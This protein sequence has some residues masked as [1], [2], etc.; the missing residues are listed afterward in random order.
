MVIIA[1]TQSADLR[2]TMPLGLAGAICVWLHRMDFLG[3][4]YQF[5]W[6]IEAENMAAGYW[7]DL[8]PSILD[9]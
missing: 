4:A 5:A 1:L 8:F 6:D 7:Y 9:V 2:V 3:P